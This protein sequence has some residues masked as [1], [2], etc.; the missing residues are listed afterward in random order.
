MQCQYCRDTFNWCLP[1]PLDRLPKVWQ[2]RIR[3]E[4]REVWIPST[5]LVHERRWFSGTKENYILCEEKK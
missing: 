5:A 3:R 1:I 2:V 4:S